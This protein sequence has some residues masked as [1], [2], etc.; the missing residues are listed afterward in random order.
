MEPKLHF[1]E[2]WV[3]II[4]YKQF[5]LKNYKRL[6]NNLKYNLFLY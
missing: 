4:V 3:F 2:R 5:G 1:L 6:L